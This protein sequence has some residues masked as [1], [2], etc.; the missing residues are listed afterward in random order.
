MLT[1]LNPRL[2]QLYMVLPLTAYLLAILATESLPYLT[3]A[4][5][6]S[7][8]SFG[9]ALIMTMILTNH[10]PFYRRPAIVK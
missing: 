3:S 1:L 7:L 4:N 8:M 9:M 6:C 10:C 5:I 2:T